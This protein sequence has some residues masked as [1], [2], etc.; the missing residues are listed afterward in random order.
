[1]VFNLIG[2]ID[3]NRESPEAFQRCT[4]SPDDVEY[5]ILSICSNRFYALQSLRAILLE[6]GRECGYSD[7][8]KV[9]A[10]LGDPPVSTATQASEGNLKGMSIVDI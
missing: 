6:A 5:I 4:P 1:M 9:C 7:P 8:K 2:L 3:G 10:I